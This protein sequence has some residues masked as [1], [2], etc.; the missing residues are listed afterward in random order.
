MGILGYPNMDDGNNHDGL[1]GD[2]SD[3]YSNYS[4]EDNNVAQTAN[5]PSGAGYQEVVQQQAAPQESV[6]ASNNAIPPV[7][8]QSEKK[9]GGVF[10]IFVLALL[11]M[12]AAGV[13]LYKNYIAAPATQEQ[14][15][16]DYFYNQATNN[17]PAQDVATVD[18]ELTQPQPV[19]VNKED[20]VKEDAKP[21]VEATA[22]ANDKTAVNTEKE[23]TAVDKA[24]LKKKADVE[25]ENQ[26]GISTKPVVIPVSAGGRLDPFVPANQVV[27]AVDT[28]KFELIAP[29]TLIPDVDPMVENLV[30]TKV[31][32]IM[33]DSS[34]PSA[35]ISVGGSDQLVHKG[36]SID[37]YK[38]LNITKDTVVIQ[39]NANIYHA[40]VG[41]SIGD[42]VNINPVSNLTKSFGGAYSKTSQ[43][44]IE[45]K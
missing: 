7:A 39:Y 2:Y 24:E 27:V 35:I 30:Q 5:M 25:R 42:R 6:Q 33:F 8:P 12:A 20:V 32:G 14:S 40:S 38:I 10:F 37:G 18:V 28:S 41:Q 3:V 45:I 13:Y 29:P 23:L 31:T 1:F 16:G 17:A 4:N 44:S 21:K 19:E 43:N 22:K 15:M 34:R 9:G 11:A 36:D 26:L